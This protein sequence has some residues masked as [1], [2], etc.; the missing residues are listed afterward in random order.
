LLIDAKMVTCRFDLIAFAPAWPV[1][2]VA[3]M[4]IAYR[5]GNFGINPSSHSRWHGL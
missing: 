2:A 4:R 1:L 3:E 5:A